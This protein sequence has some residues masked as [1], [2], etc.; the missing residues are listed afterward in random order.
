MTPIVPD[1]VREA[2]SVLPHPARSPETDALLY[3][4]LEALLETNRK[5][6][7]VS[8]RDTLAHVAR[9]T[10]ECAHLA[11]ILL[12]DEPRLGASRPRLLDLG[13]G[14]GF[15]GLVLKLLL[16]Q[17]ETTLVEAT[18]KKAL[19]LA[20][21]CRAL[22]LSG[23]TVIWS[24]AEALSDRGQPSFRPDLRHRFD[25]VTAKALGTLRD[26]AR[27]AA[28]FLAEGGQH[29]TFKGKGCD[30]ELRDCRSLLRWL[31]LELLRVEPI[32]G[33]QASSLVAIRRPPPEP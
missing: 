24:R 11:R 9:F 1:I 23:I 33:D 13:S 30:E 32:P 6:N 3:R 19:F 12:E 29:W 17:A 20:D 16:P 27:L 31:R 4:Y 2:L 28:P 26:S 21:T 22:D 25:W 8:R 18:R 5:I 15:P 10:R 7:L 14:G